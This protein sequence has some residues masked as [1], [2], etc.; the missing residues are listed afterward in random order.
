MHLLFFFFRLFYFI[1][2]S[3]LINTNE[4]RII[5]IKS[6]KNTLNPWACISHPLNMEKLAGIML[7][8]PAAPSYMA[9]F[10]LVDVSN[11]IPSVDTT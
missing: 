5:A 9:R 10:F 6:M 7:P 11:R 3:F 1:Q 2:F 8:A 4:H